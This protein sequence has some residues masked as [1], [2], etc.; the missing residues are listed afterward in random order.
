MILSYSKIVPDAILKNSQH[1]LVVHESALPL[2]KGWS[3]M[4]WQIL[5]GKNEIPISLFE[6]SSHGVDSGVIYIRDTILLSGNELVNEWRDKQAL[7]TFELCLRFIDNY[8]Y[9]K[10]TFEIQEGKDSF[11]PKRNP[12]D[13]ELNLDFSLGK[14]FNLLR[15]VD[16]EKYPA[17]FVKDNIKYIIKIFKDKNES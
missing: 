11:Y 2:G 8:D 5:E 7:K 1:N 12:I 3:P 4:T 6:A 13:S 14:Q 16:N 9:Y 17:Y 10:E 15:V